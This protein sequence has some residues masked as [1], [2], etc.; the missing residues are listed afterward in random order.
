LDDV[1]ALD[2][3]GRQAAAEAVDAMTT[4]RIALPAA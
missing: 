1:L 3:A 4:T 2:Q